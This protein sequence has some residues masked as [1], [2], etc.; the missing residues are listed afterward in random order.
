MKKSK[1]KKAFTFIE[2]LIVIAIIG[3]LSSVVLVSLNSGRAKAKDASA[4]SAANALMKLAH[5]D[6][7]NTG[8]YMAYIGS[9]TV[10]G[11]WITSEVQCDSCYENTSNPVGVR[12]ACKSIVKAAG[13][14]WSNTWGSPAYPKFSLLIPLSA[15][16]LSPVV[17]EKH[18]CV[19]S[20]G[21]SSLATENESGC[22]WVNNSWNCSGCPG[23]TSANG[24]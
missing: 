10:D 7:T 15:E 6:A 11:G 23:D 8:D 12:Q 1:N 13:A 2:L 21:G 19:G 9:C 16:S 3:I 24:N 17:A 20:N 22:G 14:Y 5:V 18:Y 4:V